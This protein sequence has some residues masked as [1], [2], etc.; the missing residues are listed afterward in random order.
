MAAPV[1]I[2]AARMAEKEAAR[3]E[4]DERIRRGELTIEQAQAESEWLIG[5]LAKVARLD[6]EAALAI[7]FDLAEID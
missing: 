1:D 7:E 4:Q 2:F 3:R 5:P 6:L